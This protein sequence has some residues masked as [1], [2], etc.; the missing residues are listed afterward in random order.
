MPAFIFTLSNTFKSLLSIV[1]LSMVPLP[2]YA[3]ELWLEPEEYQI[4]L[5]TKLVV[6]IVNGQ[7]F[8]GHALPYLSAKAARFDRVTSAGVSAVSA[9]AGDRPALDMTPMNAG[10]QVLV[11]QAKNTTLTYRDWEKFQ[12][13]VEHKDLGV[14]K[15]DHLDRGNPEAG[16]KE[17]YSRYSKTLVGIAHA[18]GADS[19]TGLE[20]ELVALANPYTDDVSAGLAVQ[21]FYGADVRAYQQ[22]EVFDRD[23]AGQVSLSTQRTDENGIALIPVIPGHTYML[24]AVVL[25]LPDPTL[26]AQTGAVYESLWANL[27]FAVPASD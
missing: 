2:A 15:E 12:A 10:L 13:F 4:D 18:Q 23:G 14:S 5:Q 27:T 3:H 24:D 21:L 19:R 26:A 7:K 16:F 17:V 1:I 9:R 25:R 6:N 11:Y 20:T 8:R 22:I